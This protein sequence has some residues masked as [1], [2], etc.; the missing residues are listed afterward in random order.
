M[1][2]FQKGV[3]YETI[4][5]ESSK[6]REKGLEKVSSLVLNLNSN[7]LSCGLKKVSDYVI[8]T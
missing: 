6:R 1:I 7:S 4:G 5:D 8:Y 2:L 3:S